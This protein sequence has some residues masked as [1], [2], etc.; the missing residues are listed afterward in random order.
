RPLL[1]LPL[2]AGLLLLQWAVRGWR[3]RRLLCC[4]QAVKDL[5]YL[6]ATRDEM[7]KIDEPEESL[8]RH[9]LAFLKGLRNSA[10]T[11]R[12]ALRAIVLG[13]AAA[14]A[15]KEVAT[16]AAATAVDAAVQESFVAQLR[17]TGGRGW[18]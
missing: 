18:G 4:P 8:N 11:K 13:A 7:A 3:V 12:S 15:T 17:A 10:A 14:T 5:E 2:P 16:V 9:D 6:R 1:S